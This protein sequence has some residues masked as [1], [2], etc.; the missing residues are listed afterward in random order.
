VGA[1]AGQI[2]GTPRNTML[3]SPA[4]TW[5]QSCTSLN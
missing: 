1:V 4:C 5:I 2:F 3:Q